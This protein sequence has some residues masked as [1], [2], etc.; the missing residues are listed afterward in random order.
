MPF[1]PIL[2]RTP[3]KNVIR[4]PDFIGLFFLL[5]APGPESRPLSLHSPLLYHFADQTPLLWADDGE[6]HLLAHLLMLIGA[7]NGGLFNLVHATHEQPHLVRVVATRNSQQ[8]RRCQPLLVTQLVNARDRTALDATGVIRSIILDSSPVSVECKWN[9]SN[10][11]PSVTYYRPRTAHEKKETNIP[12]RPASKPLQPSKTSS[13]NRVI[14]MF[15]EET[16]DVRAGSQ[17]SPNANL[18][19]EINLRLTASGGR[20]VLSGHSA[21]MALAN[22]PFRF[23][24]FVPQRKPAQGQMTAREAAA[25]PGPPRSTPQTQPPRVHGANHERSTDL[26]WHYDIDL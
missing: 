7:R 15:A 5:P 14:P 11:T 6:S 23:R 21:S 2:L 9:V 22:G 1:P 25:Y 12:P 18:G 4:T 13:F 24:T 19:V 3:A 17:L 10:T 8:S 26:N 20:R 16:P